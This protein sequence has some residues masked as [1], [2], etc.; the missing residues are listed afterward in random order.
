M[1]ENLND[2]M[3]VFSDPLPHRQLLTYAIAEGTE[4]LRSAAAL[5][6][7]I[8]AEVTDPALDAL[9]FPGDSRQETAWAGDHA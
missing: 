5:T 3:G 8:D 9:R 2:R 4:D 7:P 1:T 6:Q